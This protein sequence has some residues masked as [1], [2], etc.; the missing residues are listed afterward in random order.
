[1][2]PLLIK[3]LLAIGLVGALGA[4]GMAWQNSVYASGLR[5]GEAKV[6]KEIA[7]AN[8]ESARKNATIVKKDQEILVAKTEDKEKIVTIYRDIRSQVDA[9]IVQVP[10]YR[11]CRVDADGLRLLTEAAA[12][13]GDVPADLSGTA[14]DPAG[15]AAGAK[16]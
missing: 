7:D 5:D 14:G 13:A 3:L 2:N 1:M 16:K 6:R 9:K 12:G 4:G 15:Q 11:D 10:V 8:A